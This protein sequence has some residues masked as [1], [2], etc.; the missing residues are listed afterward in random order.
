MRRKKANKG[1][2]ISSVSQASE[3]LYE[4]IPQSMIGSIFCKEHKKYTGIFSYISDVLKFKK[5]VS[6]PFKRLMAQAF[7]KSVILNKV[8]QIVSALPRIQM[9]TIGLF[10]FALGLFSS[11]T[12]LLERGL[13]GALNGI[14][15]IFVPLVIALAGG[16]LT[17][18]QKSCYEAVNESKILSNFI[19]KLIGIKKREKYISERLIT[20]GHIGFVSGVVAGV[21][22]TLAD[23][24]KVI[25]FIFSSLIVSVIMW[26]PECGV[27]TM[28]LAI[29]FVSSTN[30]ALLTAFVAFSWIVKL[31]RGKRTFKFGLFEFILS[32]FAV[33]ILFGGSI[34]L[35]PSAS[36]PYSLLMV[37][38]ILS[39]FV[40][41]NNVK[42]TEWVIRCINAILISF[43]IK[44]T[45]GAIGI[46]SSYLETTSFSFAA[47]LI[48][49]SSNKL[50]AYNSYLAVMCVALIPF[51]VFGMSKT[52][53][54]SSR[55]M[56]FIL[57]AVAV[58]CLIIG[59]SSGALISVLLS[60][61]LLL[62]LYTPKSLGII[63]SSL[64]V[65]PA[66]I[67]L[68]PTSF[69]TRLLGL[70]GITQA[71]VDSHIVDWSSLNTNLDGALIG[72]IGLGEQNAEFIFPIYNSSIN[73]YSVSDIYTALILGI[74]LTGLFILAVII[75]A[76]IRK[77]FTYLRTSKNDDP[78][79]K[80]I[81]ICSF[82]GAISIL[83]MGFTANIFENPSVF[84]LF[85]YL[86]AITVCSADI[87]RKERIEYISDGPYLDISYKQ[88]VAT[89]VRKEV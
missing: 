63:I 42:T 38:G 24:L 62:L 16:I 76:F 85:F 79:M 30:C 86:C 35:V 59:N 82:V 32:A 53:K 26:A 2:I 87:A 89:E 9:R 17:L 28:F 69:T 1:I 4:K 25:L 14:G 88:V 27:V 61:M 50:F 18:S 71:N 73:S 57:T 41:T 22:G 46:L 23:P 13:N 47:E 12:T 58:C 15:D 60:A 6:T 36:S 81:C 48:G 54:P 78:A 3:K 29:P 66:F 49:E 19:F 83:I 55:Y 67:A 77:F 68:L 21:I 45:C 34:S 10:F 31:I 37:C 84:S 11:V 43:C 39:Y 8:K 72:G 40:I 7:D 65:V 64:I 44:L 52:S 70:L 75:F 56:Y 51:F 74:G 20:K 33:A 80:N 5:R